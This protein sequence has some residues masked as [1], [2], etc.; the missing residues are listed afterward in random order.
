VLNV[1]TMEKA[2]RIDYTGT[3][4]NLAICQGAPGFSPSGL[5][6]RKPHLSAGELDID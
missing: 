2:P 3:P 6:V 1:M 5:H 4:A